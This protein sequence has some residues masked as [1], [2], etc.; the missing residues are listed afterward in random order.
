MKGCQWRQLPI[1]AGHPN[2]CILE[3][4]KH[5]ENVY[6]QYDVSNKMHMVL[7]LTVT[8]LK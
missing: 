2:K 3:T 6:K 4:Y 1:Y 5:L 7:S 8:A